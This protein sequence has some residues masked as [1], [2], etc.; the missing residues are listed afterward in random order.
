M[1]AELYKQQPLLVIHHSIYGIQPFPL[2][3][4]YNSSV[5]QD[6]S[7]SRSWILYCQPSFPYMP[8]IC[9]S[10]TRCCMEMVWNITCVMRTSKKETQ[11]SLFAWGITCS[12]HY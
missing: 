8:D 7:I 12:P 11:T 2:E 4:Q 6:L 9:A 1:K 5:R 10:R 3:T